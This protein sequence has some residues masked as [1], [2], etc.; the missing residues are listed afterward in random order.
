MTFN[1]QLSGQE[2][3]L[4]GKLLSEHPFKLVAPLIQKFNEQVQEQLKHDEARTNA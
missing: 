2:L 1:I 4:I 3:E